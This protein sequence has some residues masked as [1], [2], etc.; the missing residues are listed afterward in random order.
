MT[1]PKAWLIR[2]AKKHYLGP[3]DTAAVKKLIRESE[4]SPY[5]E[6]A[7]SEQAWMYL[8]EC[9]PF[10]Q[11]FEEMTLS[12][13]E[14]KTINLASEEEVTSVLSYKEK[15][16]DKIPSPPSKTI[17]DLQKK[18]ERGTRP[19]PF[20]VLAKGIGGSALLVLCAFMIWKLLP[21]KKQEVIVP[22]IPSLVEDKVHEPQLEALS[23]TFRESNILFYQGRQEESAGQYQNAL[24]LY[25]K[26]LELNPNDIAIKIRLIALGLGQNKPIS[27]MKKQFL[28]LLLE[29]GLTRSQLFEIK[30]YLGLLELKEGHLP[31]ALAYFQ[32]SLRE[33]PQAAAAHFNLGYCYFFQKQYYNAKEEFDRAVQ[34]QPNMPLIYLYLGRSLEK[35]NKNEEAIRE[36]TNANRINP[37]LY[38]PYLYLSFIHFKLNQRKAAFSFLEKM[39]KRDPDYDQNSYRDFRYIQEKV[40]YDF[41]IKAY[42][43]LLKEKKFSSTVVAGLGLLHYLDGSHSEAKSLIQ[44]AIESN[45][46][47]AT[48]YMI[49]G[50]MLQKE[51]NFELALTQL[52]KALRYQYENSLTHVLIADLD[53][54][55]GRFQEAVEHCR[56]IFSFDP[57]YVRAYTTLGVALAN[58]ERM[59]EALEAFNKAL[60]YDPNYIPAKKMLLQYSK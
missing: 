39:I 47:D 31:Q 43:F 60:E 3:F 56:K 29:S 10:S 55:L 50:Y 42:S 24:S 30:N 11:V 9:L 53:I 34:Y 20:W 25:E 26:A 54:Q 15:Q 38:L 45:P 40:S 17:I 46:Q 7:R 49:Y 18:E 1:D 41:M 44:K 35:L 6:I 12:P 13:T 58:L 59:P 8:K 28:K 52:Q 27:D 14:E 23:E 36:Y 51:G 16:K 21:P 4:V 37:N 48:A 19:F 33:E 32:E 22:Q 5:D 2:K 57:F